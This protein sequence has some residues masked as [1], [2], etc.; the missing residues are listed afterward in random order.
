MFRLNRCVVSSASLFISIKVEYF[1]APIVFKI[2]TVQNLASEWETIFHSNTKSSSKC[3]N[4]F[5][6]SIR[7]LAYM[8]MPC[9]R[10]STEPSNQPAN[11][12]GNQ[13]NNV[14]RKHEAHVARSSFSWRLLACS[15]GRE[16]SC[17]YEA[18]K[19]IMLLNWSALEC[20]LHQH[21]PL[22]AL[23]TYFRYISIWSISNLRF[24]TYSIPLKFANQFSH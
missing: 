10:Y 19:F 4:T 3:Y 8:F 18:R 22:H 17:F 7:I 16:S 24:Y 5:I 12:L 14:L 11:Q 21:D 1:S 6:F 20:I 15:N 23:T 9:K 2:S 13:P